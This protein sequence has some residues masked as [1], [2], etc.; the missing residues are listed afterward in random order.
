MLLWKPSHIQTTVQTFGHDNN[1]KNR[2]LRMIQSLWIFKVMLFRCLQL[3]WWFYA[4]HLSWSI[5][6]GLWHIDFGIPLHKH[7]QMT[8]RLVTMTFTNTNCF[9]TA[10]WIPFCVKEI[11]GFIMKEV[12][13]FWGETFLN[14]N[15]NQLSYLH[16]KIYFKILWHS[17][18][19][20]VFPTYSI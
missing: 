2:L 1:K 19:T 10:I 12:R 13:Q 3:L 15:N 5:K 6:V 8:L 4:P 20:L 17:T 16:V 18:S 9:V 14:K 11:N 7:F